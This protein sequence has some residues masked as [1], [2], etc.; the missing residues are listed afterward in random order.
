MVTDPVLERLETLVSPFGVVADVHLIPVSRIFGDTS[1][2][3]ASFG[4]GLPHPGTR[5]VSDIDQLRRP[6]RLK[7]L[8]DG[9]GRALDAEDARLTAIAEA[10]ERYSA[11]DFQEPVVWAAFR[12]LDGPALDVGRIPRC[13]PTELA[14]P[15]CPLSTLDPDTPIRWIRGTD[16]H[17]GGQTWIPAVMAYY[18]LRDVVPA[19]RFWFGISTGYAVHSDPVEALV[20]GICEVIERDAIAVTWLQKLTLPV[21][22][23]NYLSDQTRRLLA[24]GRRH[25]VDS[26][27]F[28][29]TTDVGVPTVFCLSIAPYDAQYSQVA[30]C[31]TARSLSSAAQKAFTDV[32]FCRPRTYPADPPP[33][34][35]RDFRSL[36]DTARYMAAPNRAEAFSFLVEGARGRVAPERPEL[37]ESAREMLAWLVTALSGKGMQVIAVDRTTR[38]LAAVGLTAVNVIIPDLQPMTLLPLAQYRAHPRLYSAP[39]LMGYPSLTEEELNP[40]PMP[41]D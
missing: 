7:P 38:E 27:L 19:E 21:V 22:P 11:S 31:A 17:T 3:G 34:D 10:A 35:F 25:F 18:G 9:F 20:R 37:P 30:S 1:F 39:V 14:A 33:E 15:G 23:T 16:L 24:L 8:T 26:Y 36:T 2:I 6:D 41:F 5:R 29:A 40:W 32:C 12:D 28:D 4:H 13:S